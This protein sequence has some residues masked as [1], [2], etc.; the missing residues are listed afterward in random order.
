[1]DE[2]EAK[3]ITPTLDRD[4]IKGGYGIDILIEQYFESEHYTNVVINS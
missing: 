2:E 1:M 3:N 4:D